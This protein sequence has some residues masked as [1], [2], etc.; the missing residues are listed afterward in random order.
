LVTILFFDFEVT[1]YDWL[2]VGIDPINGKEYVV[3]NDKHRLER[4]YKSYKNDIWVGYNCRS[5]DQYIMKGILC[6]FDPKRINDWIIVKGRKGWEFSTMFNK[7]PLNIYDVMPNIPVSLK[8]LEGFQGFSI[9]ESSIP[10][11]IDRKLTEA[12]LQEMVDYCRFDVLNTIEVFLKRKNEFDSQMS[13]I[14]TFNLPLSYLGKTQAQLAAI[15]LGAKKKVLRDEWSIRLPHTAQLGKYQAVGDWFLDKRNHDYECKL[16]TPICGLTHT[17]A[18]GGVHAGVKK[19]NYK[20]KPHEVILDID[21]DQLYPTLMI[22]YGLL[23]RAVE[24]PHRFSDILKTSLRLK[25]EGKKKEREPYKRIC[26]I[27]YGAEGDKFNPMYDPLHRNLVCV[28]GQVLII[29]LLDKI[30][31]LVELLQ[32]NT[33]GIFIKINRSDIPELKR[34]VEEWEKRTGLKMS[35]DEF[36]AMYAKDVNNYIAVRADG[37]YHCKGAYV[38]ELNDLDYDLPIV[39]EAVKNYFL[40]GYTVEDTILGCREFRKFQK[41]VK[42]SNKYKWVEHEHGQG[43]V[44]YDNKAYRVFAS[45]DNLDGRLLKCDGVRNPAKFGNTPDKCFI[46]NDDLNGVPIPSKLD[47]QWYIDLAHKRLGDFG[48]C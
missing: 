3:K 16:D 30:E 24:E 36:T 1:K 31:D 14:Q 20:C 43:T 27:T 7:I 11:D 45:R 22:Q 46:F 29:D 28:F 6:G 35:Y 40:Y 9:H 5:Y 19:Y 44:K 23:S 21:V 38:K 4:L 39:N 17:I 37:S 2:V 25:R 13:L 12:E 47:Y 34:R 26:N 42:L 33:D 10:F 41:I 8:V 15:I 18:W 48:V 32:S